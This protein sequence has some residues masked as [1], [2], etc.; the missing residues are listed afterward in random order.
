MPIENKNSEGDAGRDYPKKKRSARNEPPCLFS[1]S[2][3]LTPG[4]P[5]PAIVRSP[6]IRARYG[7]R[8]PFPDPKISPYRAPFQNNLNLALFGQSGEIKRSHKRVLRPVL[9]PGLVFC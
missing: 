6:P 1:G 5:D 3:K 4:R 9:G 7:L 2:P 8:L